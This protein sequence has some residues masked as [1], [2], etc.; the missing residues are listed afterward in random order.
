MELIVNELHCRTTS[1]V[2]SEL[3]MTRVITFGTFD[4]LHVGHIRI[5]QRAKQLGDWLIVGVSSDA[6]NFSKKSK[7]AIYSQDDRMEIVKSVAFVDEVFIEESLA[8]KGE[9]IKAMKADILVMGEDWRGRFDEFGSLCEV[10]Y[11]PRTDGISTTETIDMIK[12]YV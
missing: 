2:G 6:L 3:D 11:L 12:A 4:I 7:H 10:I 9:Y 1:F 8:L 5:L